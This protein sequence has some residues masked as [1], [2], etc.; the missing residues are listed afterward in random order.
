MKISVNGQDLFEMSELKKKVICNEIPHE[1]MDDDFKRRIAWLLS[2]KYERCMER[3][4][5]EWVPK[6]KAR[7]VASI[8]LDDDAF[9]RLVFK[10][11]DYKDRSAREKEAN[12]EQFDKQINNLKINV[13]KQ[14]DGELAKF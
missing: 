6:L 8:P 12:G 4:K 13:K 14:L 10:Q 5:R 1:V 7:G 11:E 9:A 2:H 3:L